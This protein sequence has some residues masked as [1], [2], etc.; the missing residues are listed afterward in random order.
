[1]KAACVS[2]KCSA[3]FTVSS[4]AEN[5]IKLVQQVVDRRAD[6]FLDTSEQLKDQHHHQAAVTV[7]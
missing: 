5:R 1:M 4:V 3:A 6:Q 7:M 2:T